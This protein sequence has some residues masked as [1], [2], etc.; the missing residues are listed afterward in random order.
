MK[1]VVPFL[2][3]AALAGSASAGFTGF[4]VETSTT[5]SG[6]TAFNVFATFDGS[7]GVV[8]NAFGWSQTGGTLNI[9]SALHNDFVGGSWSP[10]FNIGGAT[11]DD[12]FLTIGGTPGFANSTNADPAFGPAGFN[13]LNIP[14]G[15][16]WFNSNPP[17]LAG[18]SVGGKTLIGR[19]V[20]NP[21]SLSAGTFFLKVGFNAGL[22]TPTEFGEGTFTIPAPGAIALLG[23][24]GLTS[25]RRR[26]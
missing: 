3:A 20:F 18:Q 14:T 16:G 19:F 6:K 12:S 8:L 15:A 5:G 9:A 10:Q 22:G 25:R 26:A 24:A 21:A 4:S 17:N 7:G 23:L 2:A 11:G 13:Q 1:F